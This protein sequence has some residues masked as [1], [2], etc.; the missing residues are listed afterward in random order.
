[1]YRPSPAM[2]EVWGRIVALEGQ[3]FAQVKGQEFTYE[4]N[5]LTLTPSTTDQNLSKGTFL[6]ALE[7]VP[8]GSTG[9]VND[10]R[11]PSYIYAILMDDRVRQGEW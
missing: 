9:D 1:L 3:T 2:E 6:R 10:L 8:L 4:V 5:G 11:G 7:R